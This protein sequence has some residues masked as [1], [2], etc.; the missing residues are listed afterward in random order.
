MAQLEDARAATLS[1]T[2]L[3]ASLQGQVEELE[4]EVAKTQD[5][6]KA[7]KDVTT[8]ATSD[9][10]LATSIEHEA[11]LKAQATFAE[12]QVE[13]EELRN[14]HALALAEAQDKIAELEVQA[15]K[16][17]ALEALSASLQEEKEDSAN[18]VS[19]LE[20]EILELRESQESF[21]EERELSLTKLEALRDDLAAATAA[22]EKA[23][24]YVHA[25]EAEYTSSAKTVKEEHENALKAAGEEQSKVLAQL[26]SLKSELDA[27]LSTHETLNYE[28]LKTAEIHSRALD[29]AEQRYLARQSELSEEINKITAEL[30]VRVTA[31]SPPNSSLLFFRGK[32]RNTMLKLILSRRST[33]NY[34]KK[35]LSV[36]RSVE[37]SGRVDPT[38]IKV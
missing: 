28:A 27:A 8:A 34:S 25:K 21:D 17:A 4:A 37:F 10:A 1:Q 36:P 16:V 14:S 33:A 7:L 32:K 18:K 19:E 12:I 22:A 26:D 23:N 20:I 3:V 29:E 6:I 38:H 35:L 13:L 24:S 15:A 5:N 11:L 30:E 31:Q 2:E 9:A